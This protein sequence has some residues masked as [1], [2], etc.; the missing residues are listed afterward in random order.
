MSNLCRYVKIREWFPVSWSRVSEK[1][2]VPLGNS[3]I[4][5][6]LA[7]T[8]AVLLHVLARTFEVL[9]HILARTFAD[10]SHVL[11]R[12]RDWR[13]APEHQNQ[14]RRKTA[15]DGSR[16]SYADGLVNKFPVR[17]KAMPALRAFRLPGHQTLTKVH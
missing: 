2:A 7:R 6:V 13:Y 1:C 17:R 11:A 12:T 5:H 14:L 9:P 16:H 4:S 3:G 8:F 10:W 15:F